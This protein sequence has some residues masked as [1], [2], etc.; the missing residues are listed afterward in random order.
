MIATN[1][2]TKE[3][4]DSANR[5]FEL[6]NRI[7]SKTD[8]IT[9]DQYVVAASSYMDHNPTILDYQK[10]LSNNYKYFVGSLSIH[11]FI[12][13]EFISENSNYQ[14]SQ[15]VSANPNITWDIIQQNPN[16]KWDIIKIASNP[17]ITW[18]IIESNQHIF[19]NQES[20]IIVDDLIQNL[21][22]NQ[23]LKNPN[24]NC[25]IK[26]LDPVYKNRFV[27]DNF[28]HHPDLT[29]E[30]ILEYLEGETNINWIWDW[31]VLSQ[32][33]NITFDIINNN[34]N[35]PWNYDCVVQ[36]PN[37][38]LEVLEKIINREIW[39]DKDISISN[40][41]N[42]PNLTWVLIDKYPDIEWDWYY[43]S[44]HPNITCD[45][46]NENINKPWIWE[47][48]SNNPNLT[49]DFIKQYPDIKWSWCFISQ[50]PNIT[51]DII[52]ENPD[53]PWLWG[54]VSSNPN[55]TFDFI[56]EN[57]DKKWSP[58]CL[59]TNPFKKEFQNVINKIKYRTI[60]GLLACFE[61]KEVPNDIAKEVYKFI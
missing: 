14:W 5:F 17:N 20:F 29:W 34:P 55:L 50:H 2:V 9:Y 10:Y 53:K 35:Y 4:K 32:H 54:S 56:E 18:D 26:N 48:V 45:I 61:E 7:Y 21:L 12:T 41:S 6:I 52:K 3:F 23:N 31:N 33:K 8:V 30:F 44:Q 40:I 37:I 22:E 46:I 16:F 57:L 60:I 43:I 25:L 19:F 11:P 51:C 58:C 28:S 59:S 38:T 47:S 27:Y 49:W 15:N 13:W 1:Q 36:N 24:F 42:N 39:N